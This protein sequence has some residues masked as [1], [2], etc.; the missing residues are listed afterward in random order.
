MALVGFSAFAVQVLT[1]QNVDYMNK[2]ANVSKRGFMRDNRCSIITRKMIASTRLH[3]FRI[4][5]FQNFLWRDE[6]QNDQTSR[7]IYTF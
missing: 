1:Y 4:E 2:K 7:E 3:D 5:F 6:V